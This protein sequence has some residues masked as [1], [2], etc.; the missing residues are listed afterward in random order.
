MQ[1]ITG[2]KHYSTIDV[3]VHSLIEKNGSLKLETY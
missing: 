3:S 2:K 1:S